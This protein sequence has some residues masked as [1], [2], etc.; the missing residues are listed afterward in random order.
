MSLRQSRRLGPEAGHYLLNLA[1][2]EVIDCIYATAG[3]FIPNKKWKLTQLVSR[4]FITV[5]QAEILRDAIRC[6][7]SCRTDLERRV[8]AL[9]RFCASI[10][11]FVTDGPEAQQIRSHYQRRLQLRGSRCADPDVM[12]W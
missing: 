5:D 4:S 2:D 3:Q 1:V 11:G 6:D 10:D 9:E 7:P 8:E 12:A